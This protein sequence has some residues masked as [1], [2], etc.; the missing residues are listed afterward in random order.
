MSLIKS[1]RDLRAYQEAR[2]EAFRIFELSKTFPTDEKFSLTD[3]IRRSSRAVNSMIAEAW[4]HR[5]YRAAFISKLTDAM[6]EANET[7]SWLD[8]ARDCHY[9]SSETYQALAEW[10]LI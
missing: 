1:F 5:R 3:Q 4:G 6:G 8:G 9:I 7:Q 2:K 10:W